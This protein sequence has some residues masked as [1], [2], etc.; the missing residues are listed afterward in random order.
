ML[1][2]TYVIDPIL[3]PKYSL[4]LS[5]LLK[6]LLR[7]HVAFIIMGYGI[8][9]LMGIQFGEMDLNY[10]DTKT[11]D[12]FGI[13]FLFSFMSY[14]KLFLTVAGSVQLIG[15]LLLLYRKTYFLGAFICFIAMLNVVIMDIGFNVS[16]KIFAIH[17]LLMI[18]VLLQDNIKKMIDFFILNKSTIP[19]VYM[20]S[21]IHI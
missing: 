4:K 13:G 1:I 12:Y 7:Y 5:L 11:G 3:R 6:T 14:S 20:L 2:W 10:L 8:S 15:G 19:E 16:I 17:I 21:L 9:K 18:I